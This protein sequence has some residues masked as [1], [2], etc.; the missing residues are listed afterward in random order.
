MNDGGRDALSQLREIR[1][2]L[3][4]EGAPRRVNLRNYAAPGTPAW[5]AFVEASGLPGHKVRRATMVARINRAIDVLTAQLLGAEAAPA[6]TPP[7][8]DEHFSER[9]RVGEGQPRRSG[10][11]QL[12]RLTPDGVERARQFLADLRDNP[13]GEIEPPSALLYDNR[14]TARLAGEVEV[15]RRS[16]RTR[17]DVAQYFGPLLKPIAHLVADDAGV[18]SWLGMFY[19]AGTVRR[20]NGIAR[21]S[22]LDATFVVDRQDVASRSYQ[23]RY[24]HYLWGSWRLYEQHGDNAAFLL[25]KDLTWW[26]DIAER[27][28]GSIRIFNSVGIIPLVLRLYTHGAQQKRGFNLRRGGLRH[29]IRV[30]DQL[31]RTYDVYGMEP[32]ALLRILPEEFRQWD[33][34]PGPTL[35]RPQ[36]APSTG[37]ARQSIVGDA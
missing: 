28:F 2:V 7:D 25:E 10:L 22:P 18:W 8:G 1:D 12:R 26:G 33:Q 29:L 30:L 20:E 16:F 13:E 11:Q 31:E 23:L 36:D 4:Q 15:Q 17:R 6:R 34:G 14:Y 32:D 27:S 9:T 37:A 3:G 5:E 35:A 24:R 21:L 19:F